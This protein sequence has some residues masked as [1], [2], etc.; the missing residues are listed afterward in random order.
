M[1]TLNLP[2]LAT[3]ID[4][5]KIVEQLMDVNRNRLRRYEATKTEYTE[6]KSA[7]VELQTKLKSLESASENLSDASQLKSYN[8]TTSDEDIM[9]ADANSNAFEGSHSIQIKQLATA[10]RL[11]HDGL[12]F[13]E[14]DVGAGTFYY[15]YNNRQTSVTTTDDTSLEE[16][17]GLINNDSNNPGVN[18]SILVYD[19]GANGVHHLVLSGKESGSD[20]AITIDD[21]ST[22]VWKAGAAFNY[23]GD[24]AVETTKIVGLD[25]FTG[26]H[27]G[28]ETITITG[29][30]HYGDAITAEVLT[31]NDDTKISH[32]LAKIEDAFD[33][34]VK[35]RLEKGVI[36]VTDTVSG[37]SSMDVILT[38][39]A[40]GGGD[41]ALPPLTLAQ[42][43][44]G[45][46]AASLGGFA[47]SDF[48]KTQTAQDSMIKV[49]GY[50]TITAVAETQEIIHPT[51][52]SG[53]GTFTLTYRGETT[54]N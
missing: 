31:L 33:G 36:Y 34:T 49:D 23:G 45:G 18:A 27:N 6:E 2:G 12:E 42:E 16:L 17:V 1:A 53:S 43:T 41:L 3:G 22:E 46:T 47:N 50:P 25:E 7:I 48:V 29:D 44:A 5:A 30:N 21:A 40:N 11:V 35:A 20:Y 39:A 13:A 26:T 4:T 28:A 54:A 38:Y 37:T 15:S 14:D 8:A 9:T 24:S 10:E 32:I 51:P 52:P 19:D